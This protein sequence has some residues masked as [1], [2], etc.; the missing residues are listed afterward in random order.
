MPVDQKYHHTIEAL[1]SSGLNVRFANVRDGWI[2]GTVASFD[3]FGGITT[4]RWLVL[5]WSTHDGGATWS[6]VSVP[7]LGSQG[8]IY[9]LEA[10]KYEAY[11]L[12]EGPKS[13]A[14]LVASPVHS[15]RWSVVTTPPLQPPAGGS[16]IGG[17]VVIN[18]HV[19]WLVEGNDRGVTGSLRLNRESQW[20]KWSPPCAS[21]GD[22]YV[23]PVA[24]DAR[25][26]FVVCEIG[27]V[28]AQP[29][30]TAPQRATS[31]SWWLYVSND[32]GLHFH[33]VR[34]L[35][36]VN[37]YFSALASPI[38]DVFFFQYDLGSGLKLVMSQ[39]AGKHEHVVFLGLVSYLHFINTMNGVGIAE[40]SS[41]TSEMIA[42]H[43]G[44][45]TWSVQRFNS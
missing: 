1:N 45:R 21:V 37:G 19:G 42:T 13:T 36:G 39:D 34:E 12:G 16:E 26:L 28:F 8:P 31:G 40:S 27:G 43:D 33:A 2:Y 20:T 32:A 7:G 14:V 15:D 23:V 11:L 9:D 4:S 44:G 25:H 18:G 38:P 5:L 22:S 17:N 41:Q 6:K 35:H 3:Y 29:S 30:P 24:S 10:S